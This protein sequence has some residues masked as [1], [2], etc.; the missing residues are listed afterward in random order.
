MVQK[1][2]Y[3]QRHKDDFIAGNKKDIPA[4]ALAALEA[5]EAA[6]KAANQ[7]QTS[8]PDKETKAE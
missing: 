5:E 6:K 1:A 4:E 8:K 2:K 7:K 3:R